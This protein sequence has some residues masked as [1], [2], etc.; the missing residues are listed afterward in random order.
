MGFR[1][2]KKSPLT[3]IE[4]KGKGGSIT[5]VLHSANGF[6]TMS[7]DGKCKTP[8]GLSN[9][10]LLNAFILSIGYE[11][12]HLFPNLFCQRRSSAILTYTLPARSED[13]DSKGGLRYSFTYTMNG[14]SDIETAISQVLPLIPNISERITAYM[15][16]DLS[17]VSSPV[18]HR[19]K[20]PL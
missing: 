10:S 1:I 8:R 3:V 2:N 12:L 13:R 14:G 11:L 6:R 4:R 19:G 16:Q 20:P 18:C 17:Q 5:V 7:V 15:T 9:S